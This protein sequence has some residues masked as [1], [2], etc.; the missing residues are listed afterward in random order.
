[1]DDCR[2]KS[3]LSFLIRIQELFRLFYKYLNMATKMYA[4]KT[5]NFSGPS[6]SLVSS[7]TCYIVPTKILELS[8]S[9][10]Y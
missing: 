2:W 8:S 10:L 6:C 1:M 5:D 7:F 9:S 3:T 4:L